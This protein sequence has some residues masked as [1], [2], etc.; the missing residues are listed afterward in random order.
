MRGQEGFL[1]APHR[2]EKRDP[3]GAQRLSH[4]E[5]RRGGDKTPP[6]E[7]YGETIDA[8][9]ESLTRGRKKKSGGRRGV[10]GV[11]HKGGVPNKKSPLRG[12]RPTQKHSAAAGGKRLLVEAKHNVRW[13]PN[14][15]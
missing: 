3:R 12:V 15:E 9:G 10:E 7:R 14:R 1:W 11:P 8:G 5:K 6:G 4:R 2:G 13:D